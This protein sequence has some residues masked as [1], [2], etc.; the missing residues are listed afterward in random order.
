MFCADISQFFEYPKNTFSPF[1]T[2]DILFT[3][4]KMQDLIQ[5][6][7]AIDEN[8]NGDRQLTLNLESDEQFQQQAEE[9]KKAN[10]LVRR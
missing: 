3:Q 2:E 9:L 10:L 8:N 6:A 7:R 5:I 1:Q 4:D